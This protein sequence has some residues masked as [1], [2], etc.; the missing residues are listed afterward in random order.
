M[1]GSRRQPGQVLRR[2]ALAG[3]AVC[4]AGAA[5]A[6][7]ARADMASF[8]TSGE[9]PF[10]VPAGVTSVHIVAIGGKGSAG[11]FGG[12][13]GGFGAVA[14]SDLPVTPGQVLYVEVASGG[15][16]SAT[17]AG[18]GGFDG[19][20][21]GGTGGGGS[22]TD[23]SGGGG[24]GASDVRSSPRASGL[25][26]DPRL[27]VAGGGG[28]GGAANANGSNAATG[29][30]A[31]GGGKGMAT[32]GGTAGAQAGAGPGV[33][34]TIGS[35]GSGG[36]EAAVMFTFGG[37]GGGGGSYGGGGGGGTNATEGSSGCGGGGGGSSAFSAAATN[38]SL[39]ADATGMPSITFTFTPAPAN[40]GAPAISGTAAVGQTL[41]CSQGTW[42]GAQP[43]TYAYQW[44]GDGAAIAG[45][46]AS[47]YG[48][49]AAD[50]GHT[51]TCGVTATNSGGSGA[52]STSSGVQIP[53][54]PVNSF[55][56]AILGTPAVGQTLTCSP[57]TWSGAQPISFAYQWLRDAIAIGGASGSG[58]NTAT[59]DLWHSLTCQVTATNSSGV[60]GATSPPI[61]VANPANPPAQSPF[62]SAAAGHAQVNRMTASVPLH[63]TGVPAV[64]CKLTLTMTVTE[65]LAGGKLI[66]LTAA[67]PRKRKVVMVGTATVTLVGGQSRTLQ[68]KLNATGRR[69]QALHPHRK[70]KVTLRIRQVRGAGATVLSSQVV[71]F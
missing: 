37:G 66:G 39:G 21:A 8:D 47:S 42:S 44:L 67:K 51:L 20:A 68:S 61:V 29:C 52:T 14:T 11:S 1:M 43:I 6:G 36:T 53:T 41:S 59:A 13:A 50:A 48:V 7:T 31:T 27:V 58:Y 56:P 55:A 18:S 60:G 25:A 45:A 65:T 12:A 54:A 23:G 71:N 19:G 70:L 32:V 9:H 16:S 28:A 62:G 10:T 22:G 33:M 34:G 24:G 57:G 40:T 17:S 35:G 63:C 30:S 15:G 4:C 46:T 38:T 2:V 5:V 3:A 69:L 26:P 49:V 64:T